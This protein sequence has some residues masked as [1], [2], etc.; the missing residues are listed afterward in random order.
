MG[1]ERGEALRLSRLYVAAIVHVHTRFDRTS[2]WM[3][4][5]VSF[6][7]AVRLFY[8]HAVY[9]A[10]TS[11]SP[12]PPNPLSFSFPPINRSIATQEKNRHPNRNRTCKY[13]ISAN[14][15]RNFIFYFSTTSI[16]LDLH[17]LFEITFY[18]FSFLSTLSISSDGTFAVC[19]MPIPCNSLSTIINRRGIFWSTWMATLY[20]IF[21]RKYPLCHWAT[22]IRSCCKCS[23]IKQT[24]EVCLSMATK[25]NA[26]QRKKRVDCT[27]KTCFSLLYLYFILFCL[28]NVTCFDR[29]GE[30][31]SARCI[32]RW[33]LAETLEIGAHVRRTERIKWHPNDDVWHM[34]QRKCIEKYLHV[35]NI[36]NSNRDGLFHLNSLI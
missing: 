19:R 29:F 18:F 27:K 4:V 22:I 15:Q 25:K 21:S 34:L 12:P 23:P 13:S 14:I 6:C 24:W 3:C 9:L 28:I 31:S 8:F 10:F 26:T 2:I 32:P 5:S 33:R 35:V 17:K 30:S 1:R 20:W 7:V 36:A 16:C 11:C